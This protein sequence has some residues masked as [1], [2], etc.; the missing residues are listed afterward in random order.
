MTG[1]TKIIVHAGFHKTGTTTLQAFLNHNR[2][3]FGKDTHVYLGREYGKLSFLG[4]RYG[5][6]PM[7]QR[8]RRFRNG[9]QAFL[10][11]VP[12]GGLIVLTRES[13]AGLMVGSKRRDGSWVDSYQSTA[14]PLAITLYQELRKRFGDGADIHFLY[15]MRAQDRFLDSC[16]RHHLRAWRITEEYDAFLA[17][18]DCDRG[19][20]QEFDALKA[21]LP[22]ATLHC[23]TLEETRT[24]PFGPAQTLID[25][26]GL[27][28][29]VIARLTHVPP[30]RQGQGKD[31]S[32]QLLRLNR[33]VRDN[34]ELKTRKAKVLSA[35]MQ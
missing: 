25:L 13:F 24:A 6:A 12:E 14:V 23:Q 30:A 32:Q 31:V 15:T 7:P 26:M 21:A 5:L 34:E 33:N 29:K 3:N 18:M 10:A 2:K 8:L 28:P 1:N 11:D 20:E 27:P 35:A 16:Y 4:R 17:N 9:V 19:L 22:G